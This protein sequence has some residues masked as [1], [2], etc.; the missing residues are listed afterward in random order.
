MLVVNLFAGPGAGKSTTAAQTFALLKLGN[1]NVELVTEFA[2]DLTWDEAHKPLGYSPY[3]FA[4]QAWRL[5]RLRGKVDI[6]VTDSPLLMTLAYAA[7][8]LLQNGFGQYVRYEAQRD[9]TLNY[10][11]V[12][13]KLYMRVGRSQTEAEA[14]ALDKRIEH[15]MAVSEI[16]YSRLDGDHKAPTTIVADIVQRLGINSAPASVSF[17]ALSAAT[18][19][20]KRIEVPD[21][22]T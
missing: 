16:G 20:L 10:F 2:K 21:G 11:L 18:Y 13:K 3:V 9:P 1:Y 19:P 17:V 4:H 22:S 6:V 15:L 12:R 8:P 7:Q 14:S 5:E